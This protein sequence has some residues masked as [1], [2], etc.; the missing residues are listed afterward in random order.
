M[1]FGSIFEAAGA[2]WAFS[3][4]HIPTIPDSAFLALSIGDLFFEV[5]G[6]VVTLSH[7]TRH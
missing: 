6:Y 1:G 2:I 3:S 5:G 7:A 4:R